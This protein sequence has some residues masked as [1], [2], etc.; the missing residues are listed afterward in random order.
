MY[1]TYDKEQ[2]VRNL[3]RYLSLISDNFVSMNGVYDERTRD[4]V[5]TV[6]EKYSIEPYGIVNKETYDVIYSEY[7][8]KTLKEKVNGKLRFPIS[9]GSYGEE[10]NR[11]NE[12]MITVMDYVGEHHNLRPSPLYSEQS[13]LVQKRLRD[14]FNLENDTFDEVF[15][16]LLKKEYDFISLHE[17][18][19]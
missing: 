3:Q 18:G 17:Y 11:I 19:E 5:I 14:I 13:N 7:R 6:Q 9:V 12:M 15:Y 4:A 1:K 10:I 8:S 2:A 16:E